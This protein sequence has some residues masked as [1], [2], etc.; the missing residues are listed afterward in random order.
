MF[1]KLCGHM[2]HNVVAYLALF[3]ALGGSSAYAANTV[4]SSD[5]VDGEVKTP[6]LGAS[7]VT[8]PKIATNAVTNAKI[9]TAAVT[10]PKIGAA[11]VTATNLGT[12]AVTN[13]KIGTAAVTNGK[14]AAGAVTPGKFGT[15]PAVR[16]TKATSQSVPTSVTEDPFTLVAFD[17]EDFDTSTLHD[18]ATDNGFL[19]APIAGVYQV[20]AG[21]EWNDNST[22]DRVL[23]LT[24]GPTSGLSVVSDTLT[25]A[26]SHALFGSLQSTSSL[27]RLNAGDVAAAF[28]NQDSGSSQAVAA[29]SGTFLA[30]HWVGP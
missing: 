1:S 4:F 12:A 18:T 30:M 3:L 16:A 13:A 22:G 9:G 2:R 19:T 25:G 8:A 28:V 10:N 17:A 27:V 20:S 5:I 29:G 14:L 11:A 26:S 7:A 23:F 21:V 6:D 15:I 24:A